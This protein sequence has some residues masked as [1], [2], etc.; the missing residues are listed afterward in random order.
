M[1]RNLFGQK[2]GQSLPEGEKEFLEKFDLLLGQLRE[3]GLDEA[4]AVA[5]ELSRTRS[6]LGALLGHFQGDSLFQHISPKARFENTVIAIKEL[7]KGF[8][9]LGPAVVVLEDL[10]WLDADSKEV[11]SSLTRN[12]SGFPFIL[13]VSSRFGDD[14]SKLTLE[15]DTG[16]ASRCITLAVLSRNAV[17]DLSRKVLGG[18]PGDQLS[19]FLSAHCGSNPF[20]I[21]QLCLYL[22]END[23]IDVRGG[24]ARLSAA[25]S[26]I[27]SA[28]AAVA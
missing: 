13:I 19:E 20:Y 12:V 10:Q 17:I 15:Q 5:S 23:L 24:K 3:T 18:E 22:C 14:G 11:F 1:L 4:L 25:P 8:S 9:L 26:E 7:I 16:I 27:P 28:R 6:I 2:P 21:K